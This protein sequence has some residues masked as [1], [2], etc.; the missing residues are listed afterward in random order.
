MSWEWVALQCLLSSNMVKAGQRPLYLVVDSFLTF[1]ILHISIHGLLL[2]EP[3]ETFTDGRA[4]AR[5]CIILD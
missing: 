4:S 3:I 5:R 2:L 1:V